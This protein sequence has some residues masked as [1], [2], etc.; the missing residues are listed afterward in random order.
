MQMITILEIVH[1]DRPHVLPT[2]VTRQGSKEERWAICRERA[3]LSRPFVGQSL[4]PAQFDELLG[5]WL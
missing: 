3:E 5:R 1:S 2:L 4:T